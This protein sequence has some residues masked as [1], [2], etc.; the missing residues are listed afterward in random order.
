MGDDIE[1][2]ADLVH[3]DKREN[4]CNSVRKNELVAYLN[5]DP[6]TEKGKRKC[7]ELSSGALRCSCSGDP[8]EPCDCTC[9]KDSG[10]T[11]LAK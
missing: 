9:S 7:H 2:L 3:T 4:P 8:D 10:N 5:L 11:K 6:S 1:Q